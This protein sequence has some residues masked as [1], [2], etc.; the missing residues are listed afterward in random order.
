MVQLAKRFTFDEGGCG[1]VSKNRDLPLTKAALVQLAKTD[2]PLTR[3]A[4][5]QLADTDLPL[6]RVTVV[7]L[8]KTDLP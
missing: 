3:M 4:V 7:Q 8:A 2:L 1:T 6:T 5:V